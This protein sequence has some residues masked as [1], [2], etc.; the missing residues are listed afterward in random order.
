[1][2]YLLGTS[3]LLIAVAVTGH[4][5][6]RHKS[7]SGLAL[8]GFLGAG[9]MVA[10]AGCVWLAFNNVA[11]VAAWVANADDRTLGPVASSLGISG[12]K[13][14][15]LS[16]LQDN[17]RKIGLASGVV[18]LLQALS[19]AC[20]AYFGCAAR[21]WLLQY[22]GGLTIRAAAGKQG[23]RVSAGEAGSRRGAGAYA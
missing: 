7:L 9:V 6:V 15:V 18:L 10:C 20:A 19:L 13:A 12:N 14:S 3:L 23:G 2:A 11:A 1:M 22:G 21:A 17:L 4:C 5:A 16:S 8:Y